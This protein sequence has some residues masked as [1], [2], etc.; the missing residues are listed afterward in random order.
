MN[1]KV[2]RNDPC[3]CGS[4]KKFKQCCWKKAHEKKKIKAVVIKGGPKP[5]ESKPMPDLLER[6]FG[7]TIAK[8]KKEE[9]THEQN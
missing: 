2:G 8:L 6:T 5:G 3:P 7:E 9:G 4:G 1:E